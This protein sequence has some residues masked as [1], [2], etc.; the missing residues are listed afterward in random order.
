LPGGVTVARSSKDAA[1]IAR[2]YSLNKI[3]GA[4]WGAL[5]LDIG[6]CLAVFVALSIVG[7]GG[8]WVLAAWGVFIGAYFIVMEG[9]WGATL[10]KMGT[11]IRVVDR[12]G[13]PPGYGRA[14]VRML[15]RL[16]EVNP[17]LFGGVPAALVVWS[18]STRQRLGDMAA[19]T[20][21]LLLDDVRQLHAIAAEKHDVSVF[22]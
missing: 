18:S 3:L 4:R 16:V 5:V 12:A 19:G 13:Q 1:E 17:L 2:T 8:D 9:K 11:K 7:R 14:F 22:D 20:Y 21:V 15:L 6:V 10:G